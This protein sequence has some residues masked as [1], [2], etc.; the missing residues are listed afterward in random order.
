MRE[1]L[2][3]VVQDDNRAS[4][5]IQRLRALVR[6]ETPA[7]VALDV[8]DLLRDVVRLVH[9]DAILRHS[10]VSL[11]VAPGL[12]PVRGDRIQLQQVAL[13]L[14]LNAFEA[15][16]DCPTGKREVVVRVEPDGTGMVRVAVC[17]CGVGF[18]EARSRDLPTVLHDQA[19]RPRDGT[20]HQSL[21][22][23]EPR[24]A[25]ARGEQPGIRAQRSR[26][27]SRWG[28][29]RD[30]TPWTFRRGGAD[31]RNGRARPPIPRRA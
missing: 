24:R 17:D 26:L 3:D 18:S 27:R 21:D 28:R 8:G 25:A 15:M 10:R 2:K 30:A 14:L 19:D 4:E 6:K 16:R 7:L 5:V 23:R 31:R 11:D 1:I 22:H 12:R 9:S 29:R 13:N 20:L